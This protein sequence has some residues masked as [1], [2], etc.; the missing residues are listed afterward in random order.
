MSSKS[1]SDTGCLLIRLKSAHRSSSEYFF[2]GMTKVA[3][4]GY[5]FQLPDTLLQTIEYLKNTFE[6]YLEPAISIDGAI[7]VSRTEPTEMQFRGCIRED[8]HKLQ[9]KQWSRQGQSRFRVAVTNLLAAQLQVAYPFLDFSYCQELA[10]D[11]IL[12]ACQEKVAFRSVSLFLVGNGQSQRI[13][14]GHVYMETK[15]ESG[16]EMHILPADVLLFRERLSLFV[17]TGHPIQMIV[18]ECL[19]Q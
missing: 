15:D 14:T 2:E 4:S 6:T 7:L 1:E 16:F 19:M 8:L 18:E 9:D 11:E 5:R 12:L 10:E 13:F 17:K 3:T